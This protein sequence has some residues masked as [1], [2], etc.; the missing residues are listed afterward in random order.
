MR[1]PRWRG[2]IAEQRV[3]IL[4]RLRLSPSLKPYLPQA[5]AETYADAVDLAA[6]ETGLDPGVFPAACP[7]RSEELL[8]R[9]FLPD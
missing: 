6:E 4:R 2:S 7:Y 3:R 5:I 8:D 9:S 1:S